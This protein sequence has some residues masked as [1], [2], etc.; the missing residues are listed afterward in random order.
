MPSLPNPQ[1]HLYGGGARSLGSREAARHH[2]VR[3]YLRGLP[4]R[5][6]WRAL[7]GRPPRERLAV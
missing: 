4:G 5:A 6:L 3:L 7:C 1:V 2:L